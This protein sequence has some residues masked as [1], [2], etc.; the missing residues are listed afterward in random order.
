VTAIPKLPTKFFQA[1]DVLELAYASDPQIRPDGTSVA[2]V[3][4]TNSATTDRTE[5]ALRLVDV[6]TGI[7]SDIPVSV[8]VSEPRWSPDG[9]KLTFVAADD[10][11]R[12]AIH[13]Y[14]TERGETTVLASV[15][16]RPRHLRWSP[17]GTRLAF[18]MS[19]AEPEEGMGR[20]LEK[21]ANAEW[22]RPLHVTTRVEYPSTAWA[23]NLSGVI[24]SSWWI[25]GRGNYGRSPSATVM[26]TDHSRGRPTQVH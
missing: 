7:E 18:I 25:F 3:C 1:E 10:D 6:R 12:P 5:G 13:I 2:Y 26:T 22:S 24:I 15:P 14:D 17:D 11:R 20:Q 23:T 8:D 16:R 4:R 9:L 21:P 19:V